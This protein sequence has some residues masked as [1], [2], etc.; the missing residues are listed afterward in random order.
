MDLRL[1][2][3]EA[4]RAP[5][6]L[7][8]DPN[9]VVE[10]DSRS[11][12]WLGPDEWLIV[13]VSGAETGILTELEAALDGTHHSVVDL[14][15]NRLGL[16]VSGTGAKDVLSKGCSLDLHSRSWRPGMC[17]QTLLGRIQ[18][19]LHERQMATRIYVRP[20]FAISLL[21]WLL[22]AAIE[23]PVP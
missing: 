9:T 3:A 14:S 19:I 7:P 21:D 22:D 1:G 23:A 8:L 12:L 5:F 4:T 15:A 18:V 16:E 10:R 13:D 6:P 17:A 11:M 20:S 2:P